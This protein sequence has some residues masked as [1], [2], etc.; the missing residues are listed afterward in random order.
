MA[1][2]PFATKD[3][4][5]G[6]TIDVL[7]RQLAEARA[8]RDEAQAQQAALAEI[9]RAINA[10]RGDLKPVFDLI[11]ERAM[12]I[13]D[14]DGADLI[15]F[16]DG[17]AISLSIRNPTPGQREY[18]KSPVDVRD[19]V[20]VVNDPQTRHFADLADTVF[21][22]KRVP[23]VV[24]SVEG[25]GIRTF[26]Q[27][28]LIGE[29][30]VIGQFAL[31]R[32]TVRP[33]TDKQIALVEAFAGHA[34]LAMG[35]ARLIDEQ[36]EALEQQTATAEI[37]RVISQSPT[38][39]Q[40]VL[41]AVAKAAVRFCGAPDAIVIQ[42]DGDDTV[43]SAHE[44]T[45][46]ASLGLRRPIVAGNLSGRAILEGRTQQIAN[47]DALDS[48]FDAG[49]AELARQHKWQAS[50]VAP[51]MRDGKAIGCIVLRKPEPGL[52]APGQI[53]LLETFAAQAVI[54]IENVR[55]FTELRESLDQ[56]TATADIL[57]VISQSPTD[58][59]PVLDVVADAARKFC[60]A[61]D[62]AISLRDGEEIFI[63]AHVGSIEAP[64]DE[65]GRRVPFDSHSGQ[66]RAMIEGRTLHFPDVEDVDPQEFPRMLEFA[67]EVGFKALL[68]APMMS[69]GT[70]V[71]AIVLR[72]QTPGAFTPRQIELLETFAAQA[73][74]ALQNTRLF[75]ELRESL[76]QQTAS[77]EILRVI[78]QSPTD[79]QP[80]LDAVATAA[81][82]FCG[83]VD[84]TV[85]LREGAELLVV[86]H[87]GSV[88][89]RVGSRN[90]LDHTTTRGRSIE[91][92]KTVH[93]PDLE[94][95]GEE[96]GL[97]RQIGRELNF[98]AV[99]STPLMRDNRAIG[100][101]TLRRPDP[102]AFTPHQIQLLETFA[103]QAVIAIENVRLFTELRESLE[104]QTAT[105]G[106]LQVISS[107]PTDV[108]PVLDAI[109]SAALR[110]SGAEDAV[111]VLRDGNETVVSAHEGT[112]STPM[113][114]R[115]Q[116]GGNS[117]TG[118]AIFGGTTV[119]IPDIDSVDR[120]EFADSVVLSAEHGWHAAFAVP[121]LRD[122]AAVGA[123]ML[124]KS[125]RGPFTDRH[126]EMAET[127]AAQAVIAIENVRLFTELKEA[128]DQ[129]TA[130]ADILRVISQ[131]PTD[132]QPVLDVVVKA[133]QR[134][135]G[136]DDVV[137]SLRDG[138]ELAIAAHDGPIPPPPPRRRL[139]RSTA[140]GRAVIDA[141]TVH[142]P[143]ISRVD[144]AEWAS[145]IELSA[146]FGG[147]KASLAAPMLREGVAVGAIMLRRREVGAFTGRQIALLEAFAAQ[148]VIAIENV[149]LFTELRQR[150]DDLTESLEYQTATS[151]VL[152]VI[153]RST[154][155][156]QPVLDTMLSA[157]LRLC[158]T[159]SGGIAIQHG[160]GFRYVATLG[161]EPEAD[162]TFR[163][164]D[165]T[166]GRG[167]L[168]ARVLAEGRIVQ[169]AD[170]AADPEY[171][172]PDMAERA[173]WHTTLGVPLMRDGQPIGVI[174]ITRNRV[175]PFTE[176]QIALVKTFADQA[177][178][179]MENA[180][181]LGELRQRT[182]DL[183]ES[184]EYQTATS[185][186]LEVISRSTTNIQPIFDALA[187]SSVRLC[188]ADHSFIFRF[189][190][191]LLKAVTAYN[192]TPEFRKWV[193]EHPIRPG[194]HS[195]AARA[196]LE[197]RTI[198][199]PDVL[200]EPEYSYGARDVEAIRTILAVP[201][202]KGKDLLGVFML[203]H[204]EVRPFTDKQ[205]RLVETFADQAA[206]AIENARLLSELTRREEEL[207]VTF[208]H[209]GDGVVMF[210]ADARLAAWNRNFQELL[211]VPDDFLASRPLRDDYV[212]L[213][214]ERGEL[215]QR[216]P[217]KE[218]ARYRDRA[219]RQ[220]SAER[221]RP[222]GRVLEVRNN[223]VPGGGAVLIYSDITKRKQAEA[224]IRAARDAAEAA[225]ERQTATADILKVI[226]SS[227]TDVRPV[228]DVVAKAAV[229]FCGATDA[230]I[231]MREGDEALSAAHEGPLRAAV[232]D[233]RRPLDRQ[234]AFGQAMLEGRTIHIPDVEAPDALGL[235]MTRRLAAEFGFRAVVAS[236]LLR[237]GVAIGSISLR[238]I[239]PG[240]F[241][242]Q[243]IELLETFAAQAV[244]A[245]ENVRLFTELRESLEQQTA[246]AEILEVISQS[247]TD[248]A[249]VLTAVAKAA[250][251]FCNSLDAVIWLRDRDEIVRV[252]HEGPLPTVIGARRPLSLNSA[253]S[254]AVA[255]N[256]TIHYPDL[257][258]LDPVEFADLR[259]RAEENGY[260]AALAAP[261][262]REGQA[263]GGIVLRK[264]EAVAYTGRQIE[265]LEAFAA[266]AVIAIENVRL[267]TELRD[268][269]ERLKAA[270]AN[271]VQSEKMA[272]LGQLTAGIAHEIKN[273]LNFVNNFAGLSVELL[274][275]LK[276]VA[277][278]ALATLGGDKRA[279]LDETMQ[280]L[281]GNLQ[282]IAE[283][284]KR[285][286]GIVKSMLSHSRG[287]SGD[288]APSDINALVEEALNLAYHGARAQDKEFNVT[289]E[290]D[291]AKESRPIEVVPQDVTRVFLNLFGNGF[292][293]ANKR[294][295][296]AKEAG[297]R[298]LIKVSTRDLGEAVE[299]RV[300]DNGIG[301][302]PEVREKLFQ[303]FFT[304]KPTGEG[305][306]LGL[307]ISYDIVTQ[308]H[309]GT[310]EVESE[311]G[312]FTEF[313]V[314]LPRARRV[315][316][317]RGS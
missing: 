37:L 5:E 300:R 80:A 117:I 157:A 193:E 289:L 218:I 233:G 301:I 316:E 136:A 64:H 121:M 84:A 35:N 250:I 15:Q 304:T 86:A 36:R 169:V 49:M 215:G 158:K 297:F 257:L 203:F 245:I 113:G 44:G 34:A 149:R 174:A 241:T 100:C 221:T 194:R 70:P 261:M 60:G 22:K 175:E 57:R 67:R 95:E 152:E 162:K 92:A 94:A 216:D 61:E 192:T 109:V 54:A 280:L 183:T 28:P 305:T 14:G 234:T 106:I 239:E 2:G 202:L 166:A 179:A 26:L 185:E 220:W 144:P 93:V 98:R 207:R 171:S 32:R 198:H 184:L 236:P 66:G 16:K 187:E 97:S 259:K 18:W 1:G 114:L 246:S 206:I 232:R 314:R 126:I 47:L 96:F 276:E 181:L 217:D 254:N 24:A 77:A 131:S 78:S 196:A 212:R 281:V 287:G 286:D 186:L 10:S 191:E 303:P 299:V 156:I 283:H 102:G 231:H 83:A 161:W 116:A 50:A 128:L 143:D 296:G 118:R 209:M 141:A 135:C 275:E 88:D 146:R 317:A 253:V 138:D 229:Q 53:S 167:T 213:L 308:Q 311:P 247:P 224:E 30:G 19:V 222:D 172:L 201:I 122:G 248:V 137:I 168:T 29:S 262:L 159:E 75:T 55:L 240:A 119:H 173:H 7:R 12:T 195:G 295:L 91:L 82:K 151:E 46:T 211:D 76:D 272:S 89:G 108:Q 288:W 294:R 199:I 293:A 255:E 112:L 129:Q 99:I 226:A 219:D 145:L 313:T 200:V 315:S 87:E 58:V 256:R 41:Q 279:E 40:P 43:V 72:R 148:A 307:S 266:Q 81:R 189:D 69:E 268:S 56:Q 105:S 285:A 63:G 270:Q 134:F 33:F 142:L 160:E 223:P 17:F 79:V 123:I 277:A 177:V 273:P 225:L 298:P 25:A 264:R 59:Q 263:I 52:L 13:C 101:L 71:G 127:F 243:Q 214:A 249:P 204:L 104:Q 178:I 45:L 274:D 110:F 23:I 227:P 125:A 154:S 39:V 3:A 163:S 228:L 155:D 107:S 8:E 244:I 265:L 182:D 68:A 6:R 11:T 133:A 130:T 190:G 120:V 242:S 292:Y 85:T 176:R 9:M 150:T 4:T 237:E 271:L 290:R 27:V 170:V 90:P 278:P 21:Y 251:R 282:K 140:Q 258:Q 20:P 312:N 73:V 51:M 132:V 252:A 197:R 48:A 310:I 147:S 111:I 260:K 188:G 238:R 38:D 205:I 103:A 164:M 153:G 65:R 309:G 74:I 165:I 208:D 235:P 269:L 302:P 210:D 42:R 230:N 115:R 284:G 31:Y 180:R 139:D 291:F 267:F 124:R 62:A 306:G